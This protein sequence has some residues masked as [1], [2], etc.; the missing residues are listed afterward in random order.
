MSILIATLLISA[1]PF[2][3]GFSFFRVLVLALQLN[4]KRLL[5]G[6]APFPFD[7]IRLYLPQLIVYR[8]GVHHILARPCCDCTS[9]TSL[10]P[11]AGF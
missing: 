1:H 6:E 5:L 10:Q 3:L 2:K 8:G 7:D 4:N 11:L 9:E